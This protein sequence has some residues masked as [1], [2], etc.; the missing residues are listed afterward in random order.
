MNKIKLTVASILLSGICF[1]QTQDEKV[2]IERTDHLEVINTVE[3]MIEWMNSDI[4]NLVIDQ[5]I[6]ETYVEN[7][8]EV[9]FRVK[10]RTILIENED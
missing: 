8:K 9:L 4:D 2:I 5:E 1:A 3:D 6:G 7:L 10:N